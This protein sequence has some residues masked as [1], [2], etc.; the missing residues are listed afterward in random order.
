[1]EPII[2]TTITIPAFLMQQTKQRALEEQTNVSQFIRD[3]L[4]E[5][6][7][8]STKKTVNPL[9]TLGKFHLGIRKLYNKRSD[10]Y[11]EHLQRKMGH[12]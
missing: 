4:V 12:R 8:K 2:K 5:K 10:L 11:E 9:K 1:M 6:I 3:A 7:R